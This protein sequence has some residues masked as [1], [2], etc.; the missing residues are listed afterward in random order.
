[1]AE[2]TSLVAALSCR[3][4]RQVK[5]LGIATVARMEIIAIITINS[6]IVNPDFFRMIV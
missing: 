4:G 3:F 1:M 2:N 5:K 6:I